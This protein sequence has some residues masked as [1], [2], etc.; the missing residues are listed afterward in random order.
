MPS[1]KGKFEISVQPYLEYTFCL[2]FPVRLRIIR[3]IGYLDLQGGFL[4]LFWPHLPTPLEWKGTTKRTKKKRDIWLLQFLIA[5]GITKASFWVITR[6]PFV[7]WP[8]IQFWLILDL[9]YY[10][11]GLARL[12]PSG[13]P[14]G[15]RLPI[16][17]KWRTDESRRTSTWRFYGNSSANKTTR[18]ASTVAR[19]DRHT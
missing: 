9:F 14:V 17:L 13:N 7:K 12:L 15:N 1:L 10:P 19:E 2:I 11:F 6:F 16:N 8:R 18:N 4:S 5:D 3:Q